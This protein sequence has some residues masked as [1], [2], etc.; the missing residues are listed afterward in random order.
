[1]SIETSS[2][3]DKSNK[4]K[5]V[6]ITSK[7]TPGSKREISLVNLEHD[8]VL[9]L[10]F[11]KN[12][13]LI[14][15]DFKRDLETILPG[16]RVVPKLTRD[17]NNNS[18][19]YHEINAF[20][21]KQDASIITPMIRELVRKYEK[22][23]LV[24][25]E[26]DLNDIRSKLS[27]FKKLIRDKYDTFSSIKTRSVNYKLSCEDSVLLVFGY[28]AEVNQF[29][30]VCKEIL[31]LQVEKTESIMF[32]SKENLKEFYILSKFN[33]KLELTFFSAKVY[34]K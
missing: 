3:T 27:D 30:N 29:V 13:S 34:N 7:E 12:C 1:M 33:G 6:E 18:V 17:S 9:N 26:I 2:K 5:V 14:H 19:Y 16:A 22:I 4:L 11:L 23:K 10:S 20:I 21:S 32:D 15:D 8:C 28:A 24:K 25:H 31:S